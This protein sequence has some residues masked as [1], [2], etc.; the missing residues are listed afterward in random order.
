MKAVRDHVKAK[1]EEAPIDPVP[2]SHIV[3]HDI[4]PHDYYQA[5]VHNFPS[6]KQM[7]MLGASTPKRFL[8]WLEN[9]GQLPDVLDFWAGVRADLFDMLWETLEDK[10]G[11]EGV[12]SGGELLYDL[13]G[14]SI[15]P[16]TDTTDKLITGLFYLPLTDEDAEQGTILF[17]SDI[18][19]PGGKGHRFGKPYTPTKTVPYVPNTA[20]F[21]ERTDWSFH[22]VMPTPVN[23]ALLAFDVFRR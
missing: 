20:L 6:Y 17:K 3:V 7:Q 14:Y 9:K 12:V 2:W 21:F 1:I 23:R 18:P 16:H 13:P 5:L 10:F 15:G 8:Y 22:G 11:V 4:F 19:D